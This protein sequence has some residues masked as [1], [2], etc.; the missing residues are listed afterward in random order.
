MRKISFILI[1]ILIVNPILAQTKIKDL[2]DL[3]KKYPNLEE[4]NEKTINLLGYRLIKTGNI[5]EAVEVFKLNTFLYPDSWN[6][7]DNL[8]EAYTISG[9][10]ELGIKNYTRSIQINPDNTNGKRMLGK[11]CNPELAKFTGNYEFYI[12]FKYI[13]QTVYIEDGNLIVTNNGDNHLI[14]KPV[15]LEK[16]EFKAIDKDKTYLITFQKNKKGEITQIKRN[17][18]FFSFIDKAFHKIKQGNIKNLI[19]D[20]RGN[21]G[22]DPFCASYLLSY[23]EKEPYIYFSKP[24]GK[25]TELS[26][27][28]KLAKNHFRGDLFFII[29]GSNFSTTGHF[30][31]ILKYHNL[32]TFI[33][34]E[35]GGTYTCNAA[36][37]RL[38]LKNTRIILKI[39]TKSFAAAVNGFPKDRGII[40]H[41][42][43]KTSIED[44]KNNKDR[45][46]DYTLKLI[47]KMK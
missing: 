46:L 10:S 32:G 30:C 47:D 36:V 2:D 7:Y 5:K 18:I 11:L 9:D 28:I 21:G 25:Y 19:I 31:S 40:P 38:Q 12:Y 34:T 16:L 13:L 35:T 37:R 29:D 27:P 20:L 4:Y 6:V 8:G 14:I 41:H 43:V 23:I 24:Y 39:A 26:K 45:V 3:K 17:K 42:I 1:I 22:G 15:D 33:G 44:F